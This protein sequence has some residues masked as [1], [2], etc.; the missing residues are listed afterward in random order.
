M[1]HRLQFTGE[2]NG[3]SFYNDSKA[4]N[5]LATKMALTSFSQPTILLAG[6]LDR[7]NGF[8]ELIPYFK[9]VKALITFGETKEKFVETGKKAG[10]EQIV[11]VDNVEEAVPKAYLL[12]SPGDGS[13]YLQH[14][15]AGINIKVLKSEV[16]FLL[17]LCIS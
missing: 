12:S 2:V 13:F 9:N 15:L 5:T 11:T 6:G 1:K 8:E 16:T 14:V 7:G 4:T 3:R 17:M 10:L